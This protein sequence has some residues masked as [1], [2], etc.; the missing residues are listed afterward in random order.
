[1]G[2]FFLAGFSAIP[3][4]ILSYPYEPE[5]DHH[6]SKLLQKKPAQN[7]ELNKM[8]QPTTEHWS[9]FEVPIY[10]LSTSW[11]HPEGSRKINHTG[12]N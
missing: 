8:A 9:Q 11:R 7:A 5:F 6:T 10:A 3:I 4:P 2:R 12:A 1:M